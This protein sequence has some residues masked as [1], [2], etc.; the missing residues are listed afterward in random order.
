M[1][2]AGTATLLSPILAFAVGL[3]VTWA[4][5]PAVISR[6]RLTGLVGRDLHK[7]GAP[8]IASLGGLAV[9][10]GFLS[11]ITVAG[12]TGVDP[13]LALAISLSTTLGAILGLIDDL[14]HLGRVSLVIGSALAGAPMVAFR[15]G[16]PVIY[17]SPWGRVELGAAFW[18][19]VPLGFAYMLNAVN[20]YAGFNG[21]EAGAGLVTA[22]S[23]SICAALYGSWTSSTALAALSGALLAFLRWNWYPARVFPGNVGTYLVGA[24]L[25]SS[26]VAGTIKAAGLIATIPYLL[27]FLI[28]LSKGMEWTVGEAVDGLVYSDGLEA[29]WSLWMARG[30]REQLVALKAIAFQ[31]TFGLAA[32]VASVVLR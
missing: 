16:E 27:N 32:V 29:L 11:G 2:A 14:F 26:I 31:A 22:L 21:L 1:R 25:A 24:A 5:T 12:F 19:L 3:A 23:L 9:L 10:L 28:R 18:A 30:E 4:S 8:E 15:A 6:C 13:E 7:P 17:S 20:I